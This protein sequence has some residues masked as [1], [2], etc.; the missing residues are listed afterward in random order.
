MSQ[1]ESNKFMNHENLQNISNEGIILSD[2]T[3]PTENKKNKKKTIKLP[4]RTYSQQS[5]RLKSSK[6]SLNSLTH[7]Q[8]LGSL[9]KETSNQVIKTIYNLISSKFPTSIS[10]RELSEKDQQEIQEYFYNKKTEFSEFL[11][12]ISEINEKHTKKLKNNQIT[13]IN[14]LEKKIKNEIKLL[15]NKQ[16]IAKNEIIRKA[17]EKII[18]EQ[19]NIKKQKKLEKNKKKREEKNLQEYEKNLIIQNIENFYKDRIF[20]I[21]D[22]MQKEQENKKMLSYDEK[23][24]AYSLMQEEKKIKMQNFCKLKIKYEQ[25]LEELKEKFNSI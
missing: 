14:A 1:R 11:E 18:K 9:T 19:K 16:I 10:K 6:S 22:F 4:K 12:G 3:E 23:R 15:K 25:K 17:T 20:I 7:K 13:E 21:K 8:S 2:Q 5:P 24:Y